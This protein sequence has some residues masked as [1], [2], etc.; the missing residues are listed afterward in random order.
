M[1][2]KIKLFVYFAIA[3]EIWAQ[4]SAHSAQKSLIKVQCMDRE[5]CSSVFGNGGDCVNNTC[6]CVDKSGC[7]KRS[8]RSMSAVTE[9]GVE[10]TEDKQ[11]NIQHSTC[12]DE[13]CV[14]KEDYVPSSDKRTCLEISGGLTQNCQED[15]QCLT[16]IQFSICD[17]KTNKCVC[18]EIHH[19]NKFRCWPNVYLG[20]TCKREEEC[21]Y[22]KFARC[23][24]M[25]CECMEGY[26]PATDKQHCLPIANTTNLECEEADQCRNLYGEGAICHH[27][28]CD[29]DAVHRVANSSGCPSRLNKPCSDIIECQS[30]SDD[31][32]MQCTE[33]KCE[34]APP[35]LEEDGY[36]NGTATISSTVPVFI[37]LLIHTCI[38]LYIFFIQCVT[39]HNII[40]DTT[41]EHCINKKLCEVAGIIGHVECIS[42]TCV[43][44]NNAK[45]FE[46]K[47]TRGCYKRNK[48]GEECEFEQDCW[49]VKDSQCTQPLCKRTCECIP[50]RENVDGTC[51]VIKN[52]PIGIYCETSDECS[53]NLMCLGNKCNCK[54]DQFYANDK[55][56]S[57]KD[58]NMCRN[59]NDCNNTI[60]YFCERKKED[61]MYGYCQLKAERHQ[62]HPCATTKDCPING[63]VDC[64]TGLC[65]CV[66]DSTS[67]NNGCYKQNGFGE[68]CQF[69]QECTN[70][71]VCEGG[72]HTNI[73]R[74]M[75]P[76][77]HAYYENT[78][79]NIECL[80]R[81]ICM[82]AED[83]KNGKC[84]SDEICNQ[85]FCQCN[86][87]AVKI[88]NKCVD[89][90]DQ[91]WCVKNTDCV[92]KNSIC[93]DNVCK[94]SNG[95]IILNGTCIE[96]KGQKY[97]DFCHKEC[98][99]DTICIRSDHSS[100]I[101][102]C[103]CRDN[104]VRKSSVCTP[105]EI[106][107]AAVYGNLDVSECTNTATIISCQSHDN[108][109]R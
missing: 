56:F 51:E 58:Y 18:D 72:N 48:L 81:D 57:L 35:Y 52:K 38:L 9:I 101:G 50:N 44:I 17:K 93:E 65:T 108:D 84:E 3:S 46:F 82:T 70:K 22:I 39:A 4:I 16:K 43:C 20:G 33:G 94:C 28:V 74:C 62:G 40:S 71:T 61:L 45:V 49:D 10:C 66:H 92:V 24:T 53:E 67:N 32:S 1:L 13:K 29:C 99:S 98:A 104:Y 87:N 103:G 91:P 64:Q 102:V 85:K 60:D 75:C 14:C 96:L 107:G 6:I 55:C 8:G 41:D 30:Y 106:R 34:C 23:G 59:V 100:A 26:V 12:S 31:F 76:K 105:R 27:N 47:N 78:C 68:K 15:I 90:K 89:L 2:R 5:A 7:L 11:C 69:D 86:Q 25:Y 80:N 88:N 42:D 63:Y 37:L 79:I 77:N 21:S 83:C 97:G 36:C 73:G 95:T 19:R 109:A 54:S